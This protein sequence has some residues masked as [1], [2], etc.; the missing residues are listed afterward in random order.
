LLTHMAQPDAPH[1]AKVTELLEL[2][3]GKVTRTSV[4]RRIKHG[5]D[6][7]GDG[8]EEGPN[9]RTNPVWQ[10]L[11]RKLPN[12]FAGTMTTDGIRAT[13]MV[14]KKV[15]KVPEKKKKKTA[16]R[17]KNDSG[18]TRKRQKLDPQSSGVPRERDEEKE[19]RVEVGVDQGLCHNLTARSRGHL[20][21]HISDVTFE[22][23]EGEALHVIAVDPGHV[24]L[25]CA[26]RK[27]VIGGGVDMDPPVPVPGPVGLQDNVR[28][29]VRQ[30]LRAAKQRKHKALGLSDYTLT[31]KHWQ[32]LCGR[33]KQR[34][35]TEAHNR[36]LQMFRVQEELAQCVRQSPDPQV[37]RVYQGVRLKTLP[38]FTTMMKT[39]LPRRWALEVYRQEQRA[40][41][42]LSTDL[43]GEI[44]KDEA[45]V[46]VW[47]GGGFGPTSRG[48]AAAPNK[49][50]QDKL[51]RSFPLV[52]S[53]EYRTSKVSCCCWGTVR[54]T[55]CT[56]KRASVLLCDNS[57]CNQMLSRDFS[58]AVNILSIFEFQRENTTEERPDAFKHQGVC[59]A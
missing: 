32:H 15:H 22:V 18:K 5:Y 50:L 26:A 51:A 34:K 29:P 56:R 54:P 27:Q 21:H 30:R 12:G 55:A 8:D 11:F 2:P 19:E 23:A 47:G 17:K 53:S 48:H 25:L 1:S 10:R 43:R 41:Q 44:P 46:L 42:K 59:V 13:W 33:D 16:K 52:I 20:G 40:V 3:E 31:N 7:Y 36:K 35:R 58:A 37:Y 57:G 45:V 6:G 24:N 28:T 14:E 9:G 39:F 49:K 4:M 38:K